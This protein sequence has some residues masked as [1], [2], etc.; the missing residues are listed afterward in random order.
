[1][2]LYYRL[3]HGIEGTP[4]PGLEIAEGADDPK[5]LTAEDIWS[6]L[7]YVRNLPFEPVSQPHEQL[8]NLKRE[9]L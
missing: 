6:I 3:R 9:R 4:M 7:D 8:R 5:K 1:M 2:D